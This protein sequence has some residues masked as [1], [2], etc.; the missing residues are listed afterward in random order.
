MGIRKALYR[1]A[2]MI[3]IGAV[4]FTYSLETANAFQSDGPFLAHQEKK[5]DKKDSHD[6]PRNQST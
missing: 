6:G 1:N 4:A 2:V 5:N 3:G